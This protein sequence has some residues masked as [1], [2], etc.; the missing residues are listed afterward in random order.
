MSFRTA[1]LA[2][3]EAARSISG[4]SGLDIRVNQLTI[5][6]RTWSGRQL[7]DGTATDSDLVLPA[8]YPVRLLKAEEISSSGGEY[9]VGDIS[10]G[11][12]TPFDG[13]SVGYTPTQLKPHVTSDSVELIYIITGVHGGEY[14]VISCQTYRPFSYKLILR[15]KTTTP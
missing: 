3:V 6:T 13:V 11:H 2:A 9:E 1:I 8:H 14:K 7:R 15:R 10:V 4:P 5:R 12:I